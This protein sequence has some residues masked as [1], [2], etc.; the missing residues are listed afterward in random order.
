MNEYSP[1]TRIFMSSKLLYPNYAL[2]GLLDGMEQ[3]K[4]LMRE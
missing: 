1:L 2:K 4:K 3:Y